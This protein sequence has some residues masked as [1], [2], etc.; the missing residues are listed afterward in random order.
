MPSSTSLTLVSLPTWKKHRHEQSQTTN[1]AHR[2]AGS[3]RLQRSRRSLTQP[4]DSHFGYYET[5]EA[6]HAAYRKGAAKLH[7]KFARFE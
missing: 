7:G 2:G 6:A 4:I 3:N 1:R 5:P